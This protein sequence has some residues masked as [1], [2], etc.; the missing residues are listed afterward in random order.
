MSRSAVIDSRGGSIRPA[1]TDD[2]WEGCAHSAGY[3]I[4][5]LLD[6]F[7]DTNYVRSTPSASLLHVVTETYRGHCYDDRGSGW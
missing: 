7:V 2:K 1:S 6:L 3:L 5:I 4:N